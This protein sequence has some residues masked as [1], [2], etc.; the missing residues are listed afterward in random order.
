V[1]VFSTSLIVLI[2]SVLIGVLLSGIVQVQ[3][4]KTIERIQQKIFH[5]Y[6]FSFK[7]NT[8]KMDLKKSDNLYFPELMN[9]FLDV[10]TL[11]K[12]FSKILLDIPLASIQI[13]LG[14]LIISIYHPLF[15][16]L[17]IIMLLIIAI[18]FYLTGKQ[19]LETSLKESSYKYEVTSWL[20]EIA[21]LVHIFKLNTKF[22]LSTIKM[23]EKVGKY[24]QF[25][26][27]HFKILL[28][29]FKTLIFLKIVITGVMLS[30]GTYLLIHQQ[31]NIGQFVA[32]EIIIITMINSVEKLI[33]NLDGYYDLLTSLDKLQILD[34]EPKDES[35]LNTIQHPSKGM[36]VEFNRVD[37]SYIEGNQI[38]MNLNLQFNP[39]EKI[40]ITGDEGSG[41]STFIRLLSTI[42]SPDSGIILMNDLPVQNLN[43]DEVRNNIGLMFNRLDIF[44][45]SILENI[46]LGNTE[47]DLKNVIYYSKKIGLDSFIHTKEQGFDTMIDSIGKRLPRTVIKKI[48]FLRAII[49]KSPLI[50]LEEPFSEL[51]ENSIQHMRDI[52]LEE[53]PHSTVF[54]VTNDA[55]LIAKCD[56]Y[57]L[58]HNNEV[59]VTKPVKSNR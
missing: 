47:V 56:Q 7:M 58:L 10:T 32:A 54:V 1:V 34:D 57:L 15:L 55:S 9:R 4:M 35:G 8:I 44:N 41:K 45:G 18:I 29:Q 46:T 11:Q 6:S 53:L 33:I 24:I 26:T 49:S 20:E 27:K 21:R 37:Y 36:K 48:L 52:I 25:R 22:E 13:V 31:L 39:G 42:Y 40:V 2:T 50:I 28:F 3:Q 19:G 16:M 23:D 30:I 38:F 43:L 14:L 5:F 51:E 12:S 17:V 59:H